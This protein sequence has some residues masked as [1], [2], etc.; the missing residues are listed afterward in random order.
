MTS[1]FRLTTVEMG[2]VSVWVRAGA[3]ADRL[4]WDPWRKR[5]VVSCRDPPE[6]N[7]ANEAVRGLVARWLVVA[8]DRVTWARA[9]KARAKI[10]RVSSLSDEE[11][12]DRLQKAVA[13]GTG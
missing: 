13:G 6:R 9:G 1:A 8:P 2:T 4:A 10:L 12:V 5:W 7:A 11:V 3:A